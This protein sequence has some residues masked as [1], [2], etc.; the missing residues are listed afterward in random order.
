MNTQTI[1]RILRR[2]I[3]R[4]RCVKIL[5]WILAGALVAG[6]G[7]GVYAIAQR[8]AAAPPPVEDEPFAETFADNTSEAMP[9]DE[10][11]SS[12]DFQGMADDWQMDPNGH[13]VS[14]DESE[15][16]DDD[17][18]SI[19]AAD[20]IEHTVQMVWFGDAEPPKSVT[21]R[22]IHAAEQIASVELT[23][24]NDW[25]CSWTDSYPAAEL[26]L[27]GSFPQNVTAAFS[28]SGENFTISGTCTEISSGEAET[29]EDDVS[30][31]AATILPQT[32]IQTQPI[33]VLLYL[34]L[35][36]IAF[37]VVDIARH[38]WMGKNEED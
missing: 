17:P 30:A 27:A 5:L 32:G 18:G 11:N 22:V 20:K 28:T 23:Q 33:F 14:P 1:D 3:V 8:I 15:N 35:G 6:M 19:D 26:T 21:V 38:R 29:H 25:R 4:A 10:T 31:E 7:L 9:P 16:T 12:N 37:G 34:G 2:R 36:F 13:P 24:E